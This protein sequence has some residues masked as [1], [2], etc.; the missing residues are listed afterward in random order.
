MAATVTVRWGPSL[1]QNCRGWF[2]YVVWRAMGATGG[3]F[4]ALN[5]VPTKE[6]SLRDNTVKRGQR[7][8]YYV[9]AMV[10]A[11]ASKPSN[12]VGITP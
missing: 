7:Y 11:V 4:A 3:M 1:D 10:G 9:V 2:G 12:V 8:R 5:S 6:L